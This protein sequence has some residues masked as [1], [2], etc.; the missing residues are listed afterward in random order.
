MRSKENKKDTLW[1]ENKT[2]GGSPT[3]IASSTATLESWCSNSSDP[4]AKAGGED[5]GK[6]AAGEKAIGWG[7]TGEARKGT[8]AGRTGE[9]KTGGPGGVLKW[10]MGL[11]VFNPLAGD[12]PFGLLIEGEGSWSSWNFGGGNLGCPGEIKGG[13]GIAFFA[14]S[15]D[16]VFDWEGLKLTEYPTE[17][18]DGLDIAIPNVLHSKPQH[19]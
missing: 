9:V 1:A 3:G 16:G 4:F 19:P 17:G 11:P 10:G 8:A 14:G 5:V 12:G 15:G 2:Y 6:D 13:G 18:W 7:V